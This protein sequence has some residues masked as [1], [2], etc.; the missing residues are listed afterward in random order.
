M[1]INNQAWAQDDSAGML[2]NTEALGRK[3]KKN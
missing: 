3:P 2:E 1:H